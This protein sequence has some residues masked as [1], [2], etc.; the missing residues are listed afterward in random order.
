M[1]SA[2]FALG[3]MLFFHPAYAGSKSRSVMANQVRVLDDSATMLED[4]V[5]FF[6]TTR[7]PVGSEGIPKVISKGDRIT[8][9]GK[10]V[11]ANIIK[12]TYILEDMKYRQKV[13]ARRGDVNCVVASSPQDL[14]SDS[15]DERDRL[16]I[17]I[18][19]CRPIN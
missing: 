13:F 5:G 11:T 4:D 16:W 17:Y 2:I 8:V 3:I 6:T 9:E 14:P 18:A 15:D 19:K 1:R 7:G 12:V 10:T